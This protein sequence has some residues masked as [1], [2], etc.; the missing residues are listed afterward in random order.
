MRLA[1]DLQVLELLD[2][3]TKV[4]RDD[5]CA[6]NLHNPTTDADFLSVFRH[7]AVLDSGHCR[8]RLVRAIISRLKDKNYPPSLRY[9]LPIK[10]QYGYTT[11]KYTVI[12]RKT[13][14]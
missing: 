13:K 3:L 11:Q 14:L 6:V 5:T 1:L 4:P 10:V 7:T 12:P 2:H 8:E 9:I